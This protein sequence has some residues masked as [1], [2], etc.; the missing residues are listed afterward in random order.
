LRKRSLTIL[1]SFL[2]IFVLISAVHAQFPQGSAGRHSS[3]PKAEQDG[4]SKQPGTVNLPESPKTC[5]QTRYINCMPIVPEE[6][7]YIC[8]PEYLEWIRTNCPDV[9]VIF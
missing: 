1:V 5:P 7:R 6:K 4:Q 2:L 8:S 3:G 9:E